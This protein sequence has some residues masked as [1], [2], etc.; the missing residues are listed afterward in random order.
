MSKEPVSI[1]EERGMPV[2][3]VKKSNSLIHAVG[4][5]SLMANKVFLAALLNAQLRTGPSPAD[6]EYYK[7]L[8]RKTGVDF[9]KGL[10]AEL[11]N[12]QLRG[13]IDTSNGWYYQAIKE[14]MDPDSAKSLAKQWAIAVKDEEDGLYGFV[15][16]VSSTIYDGKAG[17]M[18]IKFSEEKSIQN[19]IYGIKKSYTL[20]NYNRM[21]QMTSVNSYRIYEI[22]ISDVGLKDGKTHKR[23]ERYE[24]IYGISR[25][26]YLLGI[27]DAKL[28]SDIRES[29]RTAT[30]DSDFEN[31]ETTLSANKEK[32]MTSAEF[33]RSVIRKGVNELNKNDPDFIFDYKQMREGRGGKIKAIKFIV[34]RKHKNVIIDELEEKRPVQ[35]SEDEKF[36]FLDQIRELIDE[37]L[38]LKDMKNI[39]TAANYDFEKIER[40][41]R[42]AKKQKQIDNLVGFLLMAIK[43]DYSEPISRSSRS[44]NSFLDIEKN[45]ID[46]DEIAQRKMKQR[47]IDIED[48]DDD[49][50]FN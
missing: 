14:L 31:I 34:I 7:L 44:N 13:S 40:A 32:I 21:M 5:T 12:A 8:E 22:L 42:I 45:D 10:I 16:L 41:Y 19:Q 1:Y 20:L 6:R 11:S 50:S 9:S 24:F 49:F 39:A 4:K 2:I 48:T 27:L 28:S 47:Y 36:E 37:K 18:Y 30:T 46:Y 38:S 25:L 3:N 33:M 17:K 15:N 26:K 35:L 23:H 43:R 29:I